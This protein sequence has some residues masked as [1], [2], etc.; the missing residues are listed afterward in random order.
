METTITA[1]QCIGCGR[2][3]APQPCIGVCQDRKVEL[4]VA[5]AHRRSIAA[6]E[7]RIAQLE[8]LARQIASVTPHEGECQRTW[9]ALQRRARALLSRSAS[10][11]G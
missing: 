5:D 3:E 8:A 4:V 7:E 2:V 11:T 1:W 6:A 10:A 9:K